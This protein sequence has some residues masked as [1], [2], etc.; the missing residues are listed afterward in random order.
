MAE[1]PELCL[2]DPVF[3][4][5]VSPDKWAAPAVAQFYGPAVCAAWPG[6]LATGYIHFH[7]RLAGV[8][9]LCGAFYYC[10]WQDILRLDMSADHIYGNGVP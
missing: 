6:I 2:P 3:F 4:R 7:D 9:G 8:P 5:S 1:P 10:I